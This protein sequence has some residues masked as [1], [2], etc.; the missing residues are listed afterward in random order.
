MTASTSTPVGLGW[1]VHSSWAVVVGVAGPPSSPV[2]VHRERI[3]LLDDESAQEPY[4]AAVGRPLDEAAAWIRTVEEAAASAAAAAIGALAKSV[5]PVGAVG[6]VGGNRQLPEL[7][8]I[9]VSH[10]RL[11]A[12]E[13]NLYEEALVEGATRAGLPVTTVPATG[14]LLAHASEQLGV[15]ELGSVVAGLGAAI[16]PPWQKDH[17]E[18]AVAAL[19][20]LD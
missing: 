15:A 5:G 19:D 20:A 9:L 13:R 18:A 8:R 3:T 2:V 16:G 11:H 6:V 7:A 4:H 10:A 1:R 12:A 14:K 17:R